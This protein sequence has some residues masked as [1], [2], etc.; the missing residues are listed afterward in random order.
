MGRRHL[1]RLGVAASLV[2]SCDSL[3]FESRIAHLGAA[4]RGEAREKVVSGRL[5]PDGPAGTVELFAVSGVEA[6]ACSRPPGGCTPTY[7]VDQMLQRPAII[8]G[9][10]STALVASI[11]WIWLSSQATITSVALD[12]ARRVDDS[13]QIAG[14]RLWSLSDGDAVHVY[15]LVESVGGRPGFYADAEIVIGDLEPFARRA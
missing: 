14:K 13:S 7:K 9:K 15:G 2:V 11:S 6:V 5:R 8:V 12:R 4:V 10:A 1:A 3:A